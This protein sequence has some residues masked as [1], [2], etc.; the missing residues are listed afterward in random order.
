M[1]CTFPYNTRHFNTLAFSSE[2][3]LPHPFPTQF[4][5]HHVSPV[6]RFYAQNS[7][8]RHWLTY[9]SR[10]FAR[11]TAFYSVTA[12]V[13]QNHSPSTVHIALSSSIRPYTYTPFV[14]RPFFRIYSLSNLH[15]FHRKSK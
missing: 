14:N 6:M 10:S 8:L 9:K 2:R 7:A 1:F 3:C 15:G 13:Q 4:M 11:F 12:L 5:P